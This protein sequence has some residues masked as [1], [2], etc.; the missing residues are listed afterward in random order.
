MLL[1]DC[2]I[3]FLQCMDACR[4]DVC[5]TATYYRTLHHNLYDTHAHTRIIYICIY[6]YICIYIYIYKYIYIYIYIYM[7]VLQCVRVCRSVLECVAVN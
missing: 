4:L 3:I 6:V 5:Y 7:R 1:K 2:Y